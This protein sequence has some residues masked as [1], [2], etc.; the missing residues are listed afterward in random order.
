MRTKAELSADVLEG[1]RITGAGETASAEDTAM[2]EGSYDTKLAEWRRRGVVWWTNTDR[3]TE[4]IP[5]DVFGVLVDL[6][7]NEVAG[8]FG[9]GPGGSEKR[10]EERRLLAGLHELNVKPPSGEPVTFVTY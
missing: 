7:T 8:A 6:I 10:G 4:E 9:K 2:V 3:D 1:L 5:D